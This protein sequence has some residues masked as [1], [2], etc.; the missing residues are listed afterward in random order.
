MKPRDDCLE[1]LGIQEATL[2]HYDIRTANRRQRTALDRLLFG[3]TEVRASKRYHYPGLVH[4]GAERV[5][6]SV[7]LLDPSTADRLIVKL[8][9][10]HVRYR[11]RTVYVEP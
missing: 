9:E 11:A 5:G 7:I 2:I 8:Q 1:Y 10:L 4:E 6:Q 3:R